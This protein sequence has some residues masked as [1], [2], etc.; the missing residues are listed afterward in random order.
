MRGAICCRQP[1]SPP[2]AFCTESPHLIAQCQGDA[3]GICVLSQTAPIIP[4]ADPELSVVKQQIEDVIVK[5]GKGKARMKE[6]SH[7]SYGYWEE[8]AY[9]RGLDKH[10]HEELR[11]LREKELLLLRKSYE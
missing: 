11:Q 4:V 1:I 9:L 7:K 5:I 8:L 10:L 6:M 2:P 3:D